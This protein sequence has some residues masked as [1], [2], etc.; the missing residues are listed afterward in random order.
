MSGRVSTVKSCIAGCGDMYGCM[1]TVG[2]CSSVWQCWDTEISGVADIETVENAV[3]L[4]HRIEECFDSHTVVMKHKFALC[5][6]AWSSLISQSK[7]HVPQDTYAAPQ[8]LR[9]G[10]H[11]IHNTLQRALTTLAICSSPQATQHLAKQLQHQP[12]QQNRHRQDPTTRINQRYH[13]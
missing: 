6:Y 10:T 2:S 1:G 13:R 12:R 11:I 9:A 8:A 5:V 4:L 3:D 7:A